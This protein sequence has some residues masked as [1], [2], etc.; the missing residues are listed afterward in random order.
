MP[1]TAV[2]TVPWYLYRLAIMAG[3]PAFP[4]YRKLPLFGGL[5]QYILTMRKIHA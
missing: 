5:D 4:R 2:S 1:I 3:A